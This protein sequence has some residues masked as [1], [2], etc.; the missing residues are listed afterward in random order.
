MKFVFASNE[1][2]I[3]GSGSAKA[4]REQHGAV[5]HQGFGPQGDS[6]GIPTCSKPTNLP[7]HEIS[8]DKLFYYIKAFIMWAE[9]Y[10]EEEFQVTQIGCGLAG[11]KKEQ[12]APMF[13]TAPANCL[14]DTEWKP[15]L[16][17]DRRYWG[18]V[19]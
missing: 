12:V 10:P 19:G 4:A 6:F 15:F 8:V 13:G 14:F 11:W 18:H 16:G 9:M 17:D 5:M 7:D 2:G 1:L 3:H